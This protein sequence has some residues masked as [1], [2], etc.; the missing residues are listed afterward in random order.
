MQ[1]HS[2]TMVLMDAFSSVSE[3][4]FRENDLIFSL[5]HSSRFGIKLSSFEILIYYTSQGKA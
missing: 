3:R 2:H 4:G 5:F 1:K